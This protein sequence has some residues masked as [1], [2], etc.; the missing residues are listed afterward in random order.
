MSIRHA[1]QKFNVLVP[2]QLENNSFSLQ[3]DFIYLLSRLLKEAESM[4]H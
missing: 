2:E 4:W 1:V 3:I